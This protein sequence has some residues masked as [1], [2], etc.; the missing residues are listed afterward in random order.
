MMQQCI[1][2]LFLIIQYK[3]IK[4]T[5]SQ[6][7]LKFLNIA[8]RFKTFE[9]HIWPHKLDYQLNLMLT[10]IFYSTFLLLYSL[11]SLSLIYMVH[12]F[13]QKFSDLIFK[14]LDKKLLYC[15]IISFFELRMGFDVI[16]ILALTQKH[17]YFVTQ[18]TFLSNSLNLSPIYV[19]F[20]MA[21]YFSGLI[22][23]FF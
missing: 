21:E 4:I 22:I 14:S 18:F 15:N 19:N 3:L 6:I 23:Q 10:M 9:V 20:S 16:T 11:F 7:K 12:N 13:A 8:L 2:T 5:L 1:Q 17:I